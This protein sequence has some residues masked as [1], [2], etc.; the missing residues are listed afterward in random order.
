VSGEAESA[1]QGIFVDQLGA[2]Y[3]L[4]R[5]NKA[6][7]AAY[8]IKAYPSLYLLDPDGNVV[9]VPDDPDPSDSQ[10]EELLK[11]VVAGP[12]LP[13]DARYDPLRS[14][15]K[16][17]ELLKVRDF[18]D[19]NLAAPNLDAELKEVFTAQ[20]ANIDKRAESTLARVPVLGAGPDYAASEDALEK[21]EKQ[22]K[23][24]PPA[25]AAAKERARLLA[26]PAIKKELAA[27]RALQKL[28]G[29]FDVGK[30]AQRRKLAEELGKFAKKYE[31][32][33]AGKQAQT[34]AGAIG[35]G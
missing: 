6:D 34:K 26:D 3:P 29:S 1:I 13:K 2:K 35:S 27:G 24:M 5:I 28:L 25:E 32:T 23:G 17:G 8:G 16:K 20:R 4:V 9:A 30:V 11:K 22:W 18:L 10:I 31:G 15:Y 19:K 21:I 33:Y 7:V 14:L 12:K